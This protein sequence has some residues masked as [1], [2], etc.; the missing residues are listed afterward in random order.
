MR[1]SFLFILVFFTVT[2]I[3]LSAFE[4]QA[5]NNYQF[6]IDLVNVSNDEVNVELKCP[7]LKDDTVRYELPKIV[8]GTYSIYDYGRF[9]DN[10]SAKDREGKQLE[11]K[12]DDENT[13]TISNAS[14]LSKITYSVNDSY[15]AYD[16]DNPIFEPAGSNIQ[17]DS[18][19][20][21]NTFA[22]AGYFENHENLP[23]EVTVLHRPDVYGSTAMIDEDAASTADRFTKPNYHELAD[24][25]IMYNVPDTATVRVGNC[26]VLISVYSPSGIVPAAYVAGKLDTLLQA[27]GK[28]LGGSLPVNKYAFIIYLDHDE[29]ISGAQGA[30][31]HSYCSMYY[32][33]E[34]PKETFVAY[35]T[36]YAAHE[37]FHIITPLNIQSEE[38]QYFD[39][40]HPKMSAHLW[41]YEGTTEYHAQLVQEKYKLITPEAFLDVISDKMSG[42]AFSY[43]DTLPFTELSKGCLDRYKDQYGNVYQKGALIAMCLDIRLRSLSNGSYGIQ[44]LMKDLSKEY[45]KDHPFKD[46]ELFDKIG[47]LTYP[48]ITDFLKKYV[49]G[50]SPLPFEETFQM[51]GVNY[52]AVEKQQDFSLGRAG[53]SVDTS[54]GRVVVNDISGMNDFGRMIGYRT[55]DEIISINGKEIYVYNY[56]QFRNEWLTTVKEG[57]PITVVVSRQKSNGKFKKVTLKTKVTKTEVSVYNLL[58]FSENPTPSQLTIRNAW[59][60]P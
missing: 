27:Q 55:N 19:F 38:I 11:V 7:Q 51:V 58:G 13:W 2:L 1:F 48:S 60:N 24:N 53:L 17:K 44:N 33:P 5:Q 16:K 3:N 6:T 14:K 4:S 43:N 36:D 23:Y 35:F 30:L 41:L 37:F 8:P 10:F 34:L 18:N 49:G 25:P 52:T 46:D 32:M 28:Y 59:L 47:A 22:F 15:D 12:H 45:G 39:F 57:D 29:G 9:I 20:V 21:L 42:A 56:V 54:N 50:S 31:E 26:D 40:N